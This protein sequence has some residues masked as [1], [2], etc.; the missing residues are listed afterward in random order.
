MFEITRKVNGTVVKTQHAGPGEAWFEFGVISSELFGQGHR[1]V[2][3]SMPK[4][5][6]KSTVVTLYKSG[7]DELADAFAWMRWYVTEKE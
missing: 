7:G 4:H 2:L 6:F 1:V 5:W 3:S